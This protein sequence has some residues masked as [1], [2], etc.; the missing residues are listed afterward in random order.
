M[1]DKYLKSEKTIMILIF[2]I[3]IFIVGIIATIFLVNENKEIEDDEIRKLQEGGAEYSRK[4]LDNINF[5]IS[6]INNTLKNKINYDEFVINMKEYIYLNGL[7]Q[8]TKAEYLNSKEEDSKIAIQ[9]RLNDNKGTIVT[10]VIDKDSNKY[11][12]EDNYL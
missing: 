7:I 10:A 9:F 4:E 2:I 3:I 5:E 8:A 1:E 11:V 6:G 12:F